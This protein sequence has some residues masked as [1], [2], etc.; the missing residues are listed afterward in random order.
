MSFIVLFVIIVV[1]DVELS[2]GSADWNILHLFLVS[3]V[4]KD[5]V[6]ENVLNQVVSAFD[7]LE[8]L[9]SFIRK[10]TEMDFIAALFFF[11]TPPCFGESWK[12]NE[13][14]I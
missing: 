8:F 9:V 1:N 2:V 3:R 10:N 4:G 14:G 13:I 12:R 5:I 11:F 7:S 6:A